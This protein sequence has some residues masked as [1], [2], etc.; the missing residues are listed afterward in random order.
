MTDSTHLSA[1]DIMDAK[2]SDPD[3]WVRAK[4]AVDP[5][6]RLST[7][8]MLCRDES[9]MVRACTL[10]HEVDGRTPFAILELLVR[11]VSANVRRAVAMHE[12]CPASYHATLAGD[13]DYPV[14]I[15]VATK[16]KDP[17][18]AARLLKDKAIAVRE[19][20][21][22]RPDVT[23]EQA[24]I[25]AADK[26]KGVRAF[27]A[28]ALHLDEETEVML[29]QDPEFDVRL[30]LAG[31]DSLS[32]HAQWILFETKDRNIW[33]NLLRTPYTSADIIRQ[34]AAA[35]DPTDYRLV[36]HLMTHDAVPLDD[37]ALIAAHSRSSRVRQY[38]FD[39]LT[40]EQVE[41]LANSENG[42]VREY[43]S[44]YLV[45]TVLI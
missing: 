5:R 16:V 33:W 19:A 7:I 21:L 37:R 34:I 44:K 26:V 18:V 28:S 31:R 13:P 6:T 15:A 30:R 4:A 41:T 20:V 27:V 10:Q 25:G 12:D 24:R 3:Q 11:D 17:A 23:L 43:A 8:L 45:K 29:A 35:I 2:A 22:R 14:R 39:A 36:E 42:K 32:E 9:P 40:A 1:A 38:L